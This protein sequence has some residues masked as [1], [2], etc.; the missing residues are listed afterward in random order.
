MANDL[1]TPSPSGR[2]YGLYRDNVF[3]PARTLLAVHAPAQLQ[4]PVRA[5]TSQWMGKIRDQGQEGSCT[6]Q[7]GAEYRDALY[8]KLYLF[9]KDQSVS[10]TDFTA[11]AAFVY[12]CNLIAGGD[13]GQ[14]VGS[15]IHQTFITLNQKGACLNT[16]EPYSDT[17]YSVAPSD[18][19]Y[20]E[21]LA[22]KGGAYHYLPALQEIKA[23][24]ASGYSVGIGIDVYESF[25]ENGLAKTGFM[26]L[27][28]TTERLLGRHAQHAMDY[29]DEIKFSDGSAGGVFIQNSWGSDWGISATG[30]TDRG[31]YWMPYA[32]FDEH[33]SDA[34]MM[35]LGQA[36]K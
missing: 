23:S 29:D 9:E 7:L 28:K 33:V 11:S 6:G 22:Y 26:P 30:R 13:L 27:P 20:K 35:H 32:Y 24:I 15:T 2:R 17:S 3:S 21:A 12:L 1:L 25:E 36:W 10:S 8:R 18:K 31:C 14:D 5:T 34:W 16:Q 19:Q 4:L